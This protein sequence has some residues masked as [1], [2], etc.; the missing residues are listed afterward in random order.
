MDF[1]AVKPSTHKWE[2]IFCRSFLAGFLFRL[3]F[4]PEVVGDIFL[5]NVRLF[6]NY[7]TSQSWGV[8]TVRISD[9]TYY[10]YFLWKSLR[11]RRFVCISVC[12]RRIACRFQRVSEALCKVPGDSTR[13]ICSLRYCVRYICPYTDVL[14]ARRQRTK[15]SWSVWIWWWLVQS[16]REEA[17]LNDGQDVNEDN[18][19]FVISS[20]KVPPSSDNCEISFIS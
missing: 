15:E 19:D 7:T 10:L 9:P 14:L 20:L 17:G 13:N 1:W 5:R 18:E 6:S 2:G 16:A 4:N 12:T 8:R 3:P 11:I